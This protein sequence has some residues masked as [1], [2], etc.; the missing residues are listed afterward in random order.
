MTPIDRAF[1][2]I[3]SCAFCYRFTLFTRVLL[4]AGFLPTGM[5][6]LLGQRFTLIG[7]E[8]PIGA[9]FEAMYQTGMFWRFLGLAQVVAAACLLVPRLAHLGA[10]LFLPIMVNIFVITVGLD[11]RGTPFVTGPMLLAVLYLCAWDF[12][13]FRPLVTT[14]PLDAPVPTPRL[15]K[16]ETVGFVVFA[17]SLL[18][19][20]GATRGLASTSAG[21]ACMAAGF[22]AGIATLG[23]FLW[24]WW[25]R[26]R[27]AAAD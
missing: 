24:V 11:F 5:V 9:F 10:A 19:F 27:V 12:H 13:R 7:P 23:R 26:L 2:W 20:F 6:K 18:T 8:H 3:R 22:A 14:A 4:A 17:G 15:D 21:L 16:W 1:L 25:H